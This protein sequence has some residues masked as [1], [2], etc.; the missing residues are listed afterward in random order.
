MIEAKRADPP[1]LIPHVMLLVEHPPVYTL[2]KNGDARHLL[3]SESD[4]K[5]HGASFVH[6]D[7]GGDITFHGP[8][9]LVGYPI[10]DLDRFF[11]D[12]HRYLRQLEE[13]VIRTCAEFGL[14]GDRFPGRTGVW[15]GPDD[16]GPERK[17]CAMGI[18][19][20]RWVTMHGFA[21]N[22][23][24]ALEY[25]SHIIPCGISD[26]G[27]TSM[28]RELGE[29]ISEQEVCSHLVRHFASCFDAQTKYLNGEAARQFLSNMLTTAVDHARIENDS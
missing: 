15:I 7:R 25:F 29:K 6:I 19:C 8:G 13:T 5:A 2:G 10:L 18:R 16:R 28:A 11:T 26:R 1:R 14:S 21:L 27:V 9:Q 3:L 12:I 24:T 20:S 23:N 4:L 17:I 22:I